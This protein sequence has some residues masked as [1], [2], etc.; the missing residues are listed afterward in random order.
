VSSVRPASAWYE[1]S[2]APARSDGQA[3]SNW[4]RFGSGAF[5]I[6][7]S[8]QWNIVGRFSQRR[9]KSGYAGGGHRN[10]VRNLC[11]CRRASFRWRNLAPRF[12]AGLFLSAVP[13][14]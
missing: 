8:P 5:L 10:G 2:L 9:L 12:A 3:R 14:N 4:P 1:Q 7:R 6:G 13:Y 11:P